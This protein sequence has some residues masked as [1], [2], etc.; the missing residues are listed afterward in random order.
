LRRRRVEV[1]TSQRHRTERSTRSRLTAR[2][3]PS[4]IR[5]TST[6]GPWRSTARATS[7]PPR[8]TKA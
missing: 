8:A 4:S 3:K 7:S 1:S 6:S 2:R 5:T